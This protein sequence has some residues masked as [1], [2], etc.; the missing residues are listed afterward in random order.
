MAPI[1]RLIQS[2]RESEKRVLVIG[3]AMRDV[4]HHGDMLPSQD[5]VMKFVEKRRVET[6]GGAAGAARQLCRWDC[7]TILLSLMPAE[8]HM[9]EPWQQIDARHCVWSRRMPEKHR[10]LDDNGRILWRH[11]MDHGYGADANL[12]RQWRATLLERMRALEPD[13]VLISDYDKGFMDEAMIREVALWCLSNVV[14]CVAD[15][16]RRPG[17]Y[18]GAVLKFNN[19]YL[20]QN[21]G[22]GIFP[23]V[24]TRNGGRVFVCRQD[25][26]DIVEPGRPV[27]CRNHVGAGDA[28]ASVLTLA[29]AHGLPL[30]DAAA[31]AH[32]AGRC[33]VQHLHGRP[34]WMHEV[35]RD[36][37]PV[38]GKIIQPSDLASL[39]R[40]IKGKLVC[41]NGC[42][43]LGPHA[44]HCWLLRWAKEQGDVLVVAI[45]SDV[46]TRRIKPG[47]NV[48]HER[49]R[50]YMLAAMEAVD[51][52]VVYDQ[53]DPCTVL[54]LLQPDLLV[55]GHDNADKE[56]P[57]HDLVQVLIAP[58]T[59]FPRHTSDIEAA[60]K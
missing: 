6:P 21:L 32:S 25:S 2:C 58:E 8:F 23:Y 38:E 29:L 51:Y 45:N 34:A 35:R 30:E 12:M 47:K 16:K 56:V 14:P 5:G 10:F 15:A 3:D 59:P 53:D 17:L 18:R 37:D 43:R 19:D 52:V 13:A 49:D 60:L 22:H 57:G 40:S 39:R 7:E 20:K 26:T 28:F 24:V 54:R 11:D 41:T 33:Y 55:K 4:W 1:D 48:R 46:S 9:E 44:G 31:V 27:E 42:F 36:L 50:A